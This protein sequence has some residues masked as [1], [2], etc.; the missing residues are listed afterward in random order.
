MPPLCGYGNGL[1]ALARP[2]VNE[3]G[4]AKVFAVVHDDIKTRVNAYG[5]SDCDI[6]RQRLELI[7]LEERTR[8][9]VVLRS[10][11]CK[12]PLEPC[13]LVIDLRISYGRLT[14]QG[15]VKRDDA[16]SLEE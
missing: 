9:N 14:D 15:H 11:T 12:I 4:I 5:E 10:C 13:D 3:Q 7:G 1:N 6:N 8:G 2:I 16:R